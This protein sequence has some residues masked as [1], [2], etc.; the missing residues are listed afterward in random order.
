MTNAGYDTPAAVASHSGATFNA[1]SYHT[2]CKQV[3]YACSHI[4]C[5]QDLAKLH[6]PKDAKDIPGSAMITAKQSE[7]LQQTAHTIITGK[8]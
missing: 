8:G 6:N 2:E 7:Q 5:Y 1:C 3:P 4:T